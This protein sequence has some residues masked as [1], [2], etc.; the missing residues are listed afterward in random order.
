MVM[1]HFTVTCVFPDVLKVSQ[2]AKNETTDY[3]FLLLVQTAPQPDVMV[4]DIT[5]WLLHFADL[6]N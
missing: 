1:L 4:T 5:V 3:F 2:R 6:F